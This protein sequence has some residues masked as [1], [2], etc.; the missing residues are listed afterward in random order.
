MLF[1]PRKEHKK[2]FV[3]KLKILGMSLAGHI[4]LFVL[5]ILI[6][7]IR[8]G[9]KINFDVNSA[10]SKGALVRF[11]NKKG[12]KT[13]RK[14]SQINKITNSKSL[15]KAKEDAA[16]AQ[17][18]AKK[19][20]TKKVIQDTK[21]ELN[22]KKKSKIKQEV[23]AEATKVKEIEKIELKEQEIK[24]EEIPKKEPEIPV[25]EVIKQEE[26]KP[27]VNT[28]ISQITNQEI[29]QEEA[30][31]ENVQLDLGVS[32]EFDLAER[33]LYDSIK[34]NFYN[35]PGFDNHEPFSI[36]FEIDSKGSVQNI[37]KHGT[38]PLVL[39]TAIKQAILKASYP[40][41]KWASKIEL[42]VR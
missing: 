11:G 22:A 13:A 14:F 21:A 34:A 27:I 2:D 6:N 16:K 39:Y 40:P 19:I 17:K 41:K 38:E 1:Y 37:S 31:F 9:S 8:S 3:F 4:L 28:E 35:P 15:L 7:A 25:K 24:P 23:K 33:A 29:L 30:I 36:T 26:V 20:T 32:Q 18:L 12:Y 10:S 42:I 5:L